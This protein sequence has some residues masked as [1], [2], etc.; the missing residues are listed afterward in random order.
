MSQ[1]SRDPHQPFG[2]DPRVPFGAPAPQAPPPVQIDP[3]RSRAPWIIGAIALLVAAA[4]AISLFTLGGNDKPMPS[5]SSPISSRRPTFSTTPTVGETS[6]LPWKG[7]NGKGSWEI[8]DERWDDS[9]VTL[10]VTVRCEEGSLSWD[11]FAYPQEGNDALDP[12]S[13][14]PSPYIAKGSCSGTSEQRGYVRITFPRRGPGMLIL[15]SRLSPVSGL[16]IRG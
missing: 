12:A 9:T 4:M 2:R 14:G 10:D 5:T 11:F 13:D 1:Q 7:K 15:A 3:P 6:S 16:R 8:H